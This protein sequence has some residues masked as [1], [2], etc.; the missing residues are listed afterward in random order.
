VIRQLEVNLK[1]SVCHLFKKMTPP[2]QSDAS[3]AAH[4]EKLYML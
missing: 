1:V 2:A 3:S 4:Y